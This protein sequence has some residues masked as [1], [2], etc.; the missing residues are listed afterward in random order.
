M[1]KNAFYLLITLLLLS[2]VGIS[3]CSD[4]KKTG[5]LSG[6]VPLALLGTGKTSLPPINKTYPTEETIVL[7]IGQQLNLSPSQ[8]VEGSEY[9]ISPQLPDGLNLDPK[10]GVISGTSTASF[11]AT[12]FTITQTKS[13]GTKTSWKVTIGVNGN[14][15][16]ISTAESATPTFN[17]PA[18]YYNEPKYISITTSLSGAAVRCTFDG[19]EP[20]SSSEE[21]TQ[22]LHIWSIAG[23]TLKCK[24]FKNGTSFGETV[25]AIYSYPPLKT[26]QTAVYVTGDDGTNQSGIVRSYSGP[27]QNKTFTS[28]YTT[29]DNATGLIWKTCSQ[30]LSG[31]N[32]AAGS[33]TVMNWADA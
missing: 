13:D 31:A 26:G 18:G 29:T 8:H 17:L 1:K 4:R 12:V 30:G 6:I 16:N 15:S 7:N 25:S 5:V 10:T 33:A 11:P 9:T 19:T 20:S 22:P 32:C 27:T 28:D 24:A 2:F 21:F 23:K 3:N 14:G